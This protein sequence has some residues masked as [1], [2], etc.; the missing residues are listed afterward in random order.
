MCCVQTLAIDLLNPSNEAEQQKHKLKRLVQSPNSFFMVSN[1]MYSQ[2]TA[3]LFTNDG[4]D[5]AHGG[6]GAGR[7][8]SRGEGKGRPPR[9]RGSLSSP[10]QAGSRPCKGSERSCWGVLREARMVLGMVRGAL[11][12]WRAHG[13][14]HTTVP[15]GPP[16][17]ALASRPAAPAASFN[18]LHHAR[19]TAVIPEPVERPYGLPSLRPGP[20]PLDH[21]TAIGSEMSCFAL[22]RR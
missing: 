15:A 21:R 19:D 6:L 20:P 4:I 11:E 7:Q 17:A 18:V 22:A 10:G 13:R 14:G 3:T 16:T 1:S 8:R 2:S 9:L 12:W 5:R